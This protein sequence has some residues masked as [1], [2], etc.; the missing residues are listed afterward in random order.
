MRI[1]CINSTSGRKSVTGNEFSGTNFLYDV[2]SF[3][4]RRDFSLRAQIRPYCYFRKN[5]TSYLN[6][7]PPFLPECD[8]VTFGSLLSQFRLSSVTLVHP[9]QGV[10]PFG[11]L[12]SPLC[13]LA[14]H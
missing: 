11:K 13:T 9:T 14:I 8:Y 10:E 5:L 3:S 4:V 6:S 1:K 7:A 12:S 2:E